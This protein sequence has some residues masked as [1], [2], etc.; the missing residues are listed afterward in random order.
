M[1]TK[2]PILDKFHLHPFGGRCTCFSNPYDMCIICKRSSE[3][4]KRWDSLLPED[5]I[6]AEAEMDIVY[7]KTDNQDGR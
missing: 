7:P 5:R 4:R 2:T 1:P 6:K 3:F